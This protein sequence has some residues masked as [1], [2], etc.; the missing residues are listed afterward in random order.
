MYTIT[1]L[2]CV[3]VYAIWFTFETSDFIHIL[4]LII[5]DRYCRNCIYIG[6][7]ILQNILLL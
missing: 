7:K 4:F 1:N 5:L 2:V 6:F 3:C